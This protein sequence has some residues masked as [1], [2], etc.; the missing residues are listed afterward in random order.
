MT[1]V[2]LPLATGFEEIEA[3]TVIDVLR[4]A[5]IEVTVAGLIPGPLVGSRGIRLHPDTTLD[6]VDP[7]GFDLV[8]LPGGLGGTEAMMAD[9]RLLDL[10]R[11]HRAAGRTIAAICAAPMVLVA[12]GLEEGV[13]VTSHPSVRGRLGR[14]AVAE[15]D[16]QGPAV[17]EDSGFITSQGPGTAMEFALYLVEHLAGPQLRASLAAAMIVN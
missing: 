4:R 10:L 8:V 2:L 15:E 1:Q 11:A 9:P 12:A 5:E 14:A 3:V 17:V 13:R 7:N 6:E 16:L